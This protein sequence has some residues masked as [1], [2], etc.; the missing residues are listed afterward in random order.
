MS[1]S[2]ICRRLGG[3][4]RSK[5]LGFS[6]LPVTVKSFG[7]TLCSGLSVCSCSVIAWVAIGV[8]VV[9]GVGSLVAPD[10]FVETP[11]ARV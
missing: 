9:I 10:R 6:G 1:V 4:G 11:R 8:A 5:S 2:P 7:G 3:V